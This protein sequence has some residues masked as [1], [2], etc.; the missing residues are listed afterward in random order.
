MGK[1]KTTDTGKSVQQAGEPDVPAQTEQP[2]SDQLAAMSAEISQVE[3]EIEQAR[4]AI[5]ATPARLAQ[6]KGDFDRAFLAADEA[7]QA[8]ALVTIRRVNEERAAAITKLDAFRHPLTALSARVASLQSAVLARVTAAG[9]AFERTR[10]ENA[11]AG[12][13]L[14]AVGAT[15]SRLSSVRSMQERQ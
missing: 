8:A 3:T 15:A 14:D 13:L 2:L 1:T 11:Q 9:E 5:R 4:N 12:R 10:V 6:A 7:G